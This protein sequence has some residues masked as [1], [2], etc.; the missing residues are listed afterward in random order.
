VCSIYEQRPLA[1]REHYVKHSA[2]ACRS[3]Y[4]IPKVL[5][6]PVQVP[7]A[8]GQLASELEGTS[9]EA[10][11]LPLVLVWYEEN[12]DRAEQTWPCSMMV[13]RFVEIIKVMASRSSTALVV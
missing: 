11:I 1:C 10:V 8:L 5:E 3:V 6:M 2:E 4:V 7:N 12:S 9:I 13:K